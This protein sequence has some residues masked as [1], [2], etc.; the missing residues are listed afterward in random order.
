MK[1]GY[2]LCPRCDAITSI[3]I[4]FNPQRFLRIRFPSTSIRWI[5]PAY[6][7]ATLQSGNF[8]I[9]S[10]CGNLWTLDPEFFYAVTWKNRAQFFTVKGRARSKFRALYDACSAANIPRGVQWIGLNTCTCG[11]GIFFN[12]DQKSCGFKNIRVRVEG[13]WMWCLAVIIGRKKPAFWLFSTSK[14][15]NFARLVFK[16]SD[17]IKC[18]TTII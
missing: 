15:V 6:E 12:P 7:S 9:R 16:K 2:R 8:W 5:R 14:V 3:R 10:E 18:A 17:W 4:F 11:R 1:C 13:G